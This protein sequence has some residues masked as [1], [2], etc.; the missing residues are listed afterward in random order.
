MNDYEE[1]RWSQLG[2]WPMSFLPKYNVQ[3]H[4]CHCNV[5]LGRVVKTCGSNSTQT[6]LITGSI[7][8]L[9]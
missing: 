5:C 7:T 9:N 2:S 4:I 6:K 1:S 8:F 3:E